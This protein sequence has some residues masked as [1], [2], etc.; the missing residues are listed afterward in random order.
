M[1]L[2]KLAK[3]VVDTYG[4]LHQTNL[5][6]LR[7]YIR[8]TSEEELAKEI[9]KMVSW[10]EL[11]TLWEAGLNTRLQDEVLKRLKEIE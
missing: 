7:H 4:L 2:Q 1:K 11:R 5:G 8:T 9:G 3:K 6:V 10:K